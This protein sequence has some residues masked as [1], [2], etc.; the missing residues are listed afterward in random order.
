M[1]T[2]SPSGGVDRDL[3]SIDSATGVVTFDTAPDHENPADADT[4]NV[5][6]IQVS[7][8]AN[9]KTVTQDVAITVTNVDDNDPV[10]TSLPTA[11]AAE[12]RLINAQFGKKLVSSIF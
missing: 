5:Y 4:N 9:G 1:V 12:I 10:I 6:N 11:S 7:A 8:T 3:F 2:R